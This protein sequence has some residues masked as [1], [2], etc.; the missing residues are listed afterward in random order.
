VLASRQI[1]LSEY[2][3]KVNSINHKKG[4]LMSFKQFFYINNLYTKALLKEI[5]YLENV[6][7]DKLRK[8]TIYANPEFKKLIA[9]EYPEVK[10]TYL[11]Q[12]SYL[13]Q[14]ISK[15]YEA[16]AAAKKQ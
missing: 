3:K 14:K 11:N 9:N 13:R 8:D 16:Q 5:N 4:T 1:L 10:K 7:N 2:E 6:V 15:A 12:D